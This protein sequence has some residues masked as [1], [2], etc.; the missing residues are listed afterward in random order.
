MIQFATLLA[1]KDILLE[2][3][4]GADFLE[5]TLNGGIIAL[6]PYHDHLPGF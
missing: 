6:Y 3:I 4:S 2:G 5:M 1:N